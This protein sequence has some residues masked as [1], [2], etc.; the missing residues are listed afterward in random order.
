MFELCASILAADFAN[1]ERDMR[2]ANAGDQSSC[3]SAGRAPRRSIL[4]LSTTE[5]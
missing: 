3:G 2:A 5:V 1:L 4:R